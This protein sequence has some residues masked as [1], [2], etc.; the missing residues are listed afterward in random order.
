MISYFE[1]GTLVSIPNFYNNRRF[2]KTVFDPSSNSLKFDNFK[3]F[4]KITVSFYKRFNNI[5]SLP[6]SDTIYIPCRQNYDQS[7]YP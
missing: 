5:S 2:V 4:K 3:L 6:N 7:I 1:S